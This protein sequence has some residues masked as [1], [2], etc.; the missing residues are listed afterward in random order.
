[1]EKPINFVDLKK[2]L[3]ILRKSLDY[4]NVRSCKKRLDVIIKEYFGDI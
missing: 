4:R 2:E 3:K 1:M